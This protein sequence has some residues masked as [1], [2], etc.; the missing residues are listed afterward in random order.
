MFRFE[1]TRIARERYL[2]PDKKTPA[3]QSWHSS[4]FS[5]GF[6]GNR[7]FIWPHRPIDIPL[8][9]QT[10]PNNKDVSNLEFLPGRLVRCAGPCWGPDHCEDGDRNG[11]SIRRW[12][13]HPL[14]KEWI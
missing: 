13:D 1:K 12:P 11:S 14:S 7:R 10:R 5:F 2:N 6:A 4:F 8:A 9:A 3:I